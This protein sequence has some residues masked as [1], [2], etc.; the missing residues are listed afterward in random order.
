[1]N[2]DQDG[3]T[4]RILI[5]EN[6]DRISTYYFFQVNALSDEQEISKGPFKTEL[7]GS[8]SP[9][10]ET[11]IPEKNLTWKNHWVSSDQT[12]PQSICSSPCGHKHAEIHQE[13]V[14]CW[15]CQ[16]CR[17]NEYVTDGRT[18]CKTCS[19]YTW[20]DANT[21]WTS[22]KDIPV[23]KPDFGEVTV[24]LALILALISFSICLAVLVFF[25]HH[26]EKIAIKN[27]L[28]QLSFLMLLSIF[29]GN[30]TVVIFQFEPNDLN[31]EVI[32]LLFCFSFALMYG[33]LVI[34]TFVN[35]HKFT[36]PTAGQKSDWII[37]VTPC[38]QVILT[39][40]L[41]LIQVSIKISFVLMFQL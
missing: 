1:M 2:T 21:N 13:N 34:R 9:L 3:Y 12:S 7:V 23:D 26:R 8:F 30:V 4:G 19:L 32:F 6:G 41:V 38:C 10:Y 40:G 16:A 31:C 36:Y 25:V 5:D 14:C 11:F 20:P 27:S 29:I 15:I 37:K 17:N 18:H 39:L 33:S 28:P 22:C 35:L 24:L